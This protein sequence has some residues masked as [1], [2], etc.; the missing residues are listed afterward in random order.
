MSLSMDMETEGFDD[1]MH[2]VDAFPEVVATRM[3]VALRRIGQIVTPVLKALTPRRS[4]R[5][6]NSTRFQLVGRGTAQQLEIRQGARTQNGSFYGHFVRGGTR[7][8]FITAV[9]AKSLRFQIGERVIFRQSVNHPGTKP[10]PYHQAAVLQTKAQVQQVVS[11]EGVVVSAHLADI[12][13]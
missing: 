3:N 12:K 4:N 10:N 13:P 8:H 9:H 1:L 11:G 7:P 5:L 6:A 2:N